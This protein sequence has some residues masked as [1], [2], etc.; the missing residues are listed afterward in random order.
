MTQRTEVFEEI[1]R[2]LDSGKQ[3]DVLYVDMSKAFDKVS[4][5]LLLQRLHEFGFRGNIM[6]QRCNL[7]LARGK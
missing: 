4:H 5:S 7:T 6:K 3:I 2:Q 1:G